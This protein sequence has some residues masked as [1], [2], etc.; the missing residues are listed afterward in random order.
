MENAFITPITQKRIIYKLARYINELQN[1]R[2][3]I[4][5]HKSR[6]EILRTT[7]IDIDILEKQL[8]NF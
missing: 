2:H 7:N 4:L 1:V 3:M 5:D 6:D 8:E